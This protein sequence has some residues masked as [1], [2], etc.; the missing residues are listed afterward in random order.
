MNVASSQLL[1]TCGHRTSMYVVTRQTGNYS[2]VDRPELQALSGKTIEDLFREAGT[3]LSEDFALAPLST[4][5][6]SAT[7]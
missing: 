4:P 5:L 1:L 3:V 6:V 7:P 2:F